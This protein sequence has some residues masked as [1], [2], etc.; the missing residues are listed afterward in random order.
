M[1]EIK[2]NSKILPSCIPLPLEPK[3]LEE[4]VTK[5]RDYALM[6][7]ICMRPKADYNPDSLKVSRRNFNS[8][9]PN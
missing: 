8:R 2:T 3:V 4:I 5:A 9:S 1:S 7:G 6:H